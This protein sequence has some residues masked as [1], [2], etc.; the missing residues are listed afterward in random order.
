MKRFYLVRHGETDWNKYNM[1]QGCI[2]TDL[3]QTGIEQAKK[4]AERLRSEKIDIIFSSTLKRAYMTANQ[5]KSFHPNIPLKL[6]DKLNE[7]NFGE[8]E[9][10][11]F[12]ELE[13]RYSEQYKLWKDAPEKA[14]FPGEGSLYNVMERVKSFFEGILNKPYKNVVIVTHGGI[15]KLSIIYLLELPLDFYKKCWFGNASLSIVDIK[16]NRRML[17][18]LNDMSHL[19]TI[20]RYPMI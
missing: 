4:V 18:L 5:I 14:T 7:I 6:T 15:I 1:V 3:N 12:E 11:N 20:Q 19:Q 13:E 10:L 9:G 16:E 17:S 8:W 2:D